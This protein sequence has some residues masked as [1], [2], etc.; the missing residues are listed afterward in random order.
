MACQINEKT[1]EICDILDGNPQLLNSEAQRN[2]KIVRDVAEF[3][4]SVT[5]R[6][7]VNFRNVCSS[8]NSIH[9]INHRSDDSELTPFPHP[10]YDTNKI[11]R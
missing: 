2:C 6:N 7:I 5:N 8:F 9:E 10:A 1:A 11:Y 3:C 4:D